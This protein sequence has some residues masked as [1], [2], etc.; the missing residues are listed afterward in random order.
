[1][2]TD[3]LK[4][5]KAISSALGVRKES[6]ITSLGLALSYAIQL[7]LVFFVKDV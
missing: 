5:P 1:M 2:Q 3:L 4:T 6:V 7:E